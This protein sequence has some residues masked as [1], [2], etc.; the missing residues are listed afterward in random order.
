MSP[1]LALGALAAAPTGSA[2]R[3]NGAKQEAGGGVVRILLVPAHVHCMTRTLGGGAVC[4]AADKPWQPARRCP[5]AALCPTL[6]W[7]IG[8]SQPGAQHGPVPAA[9]S[10]L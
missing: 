6:A 1:D 3:G 2:G 4:S 10:T 8:G 7:L 9:A 5:C